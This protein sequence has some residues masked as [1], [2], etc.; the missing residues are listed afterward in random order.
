MKNI[1]LITNQFGVQSDLERIGSEHA[2]GFDVYDSVENA[3]TAIKESLPEIVLFDVTH[4][5]TDPEIAIRRMK[6]SAP[7]SSFILIM[8]RGL[9][10]ELSVVHK[11]GA[12]DYLLY[13]FKEDR[14][15]VTID[16]IYEHI[17]LKK[18][19]Q[20]LENGKK[21]AQL[22]NWLIGE[23]DAINAVRDR[24]KSIRNSRENVFITGESGTGKKYCAE[25]IHNHCERTNR[26]FIHIDARDG[27][28]QDMER[29]LVKADGG[30]LYVSHI[31]DLPPTD[32]TVLN[33]FLASDKSNE[34]L[35]IVSSQLSDHE[36]AAH[37]NLSPDLYYRLHIVPIRMPALRERRED[38]AM[39]AEHFLDELGQKHDK[40]F[41]R[42]KKD[43]M[44]MFKIYDW[45]GNVR[46][47]KNTIRSII[48]LNPTSK[49]DI[50]LS[51]L[52]TP[53]KNIPANA[54]D[55]N[56]GGMG[57]FETDEIVSIPDLER[58]AIKHALEVCHGNVQEAAMR[59]KI[60][61]ATLYRKRE[62]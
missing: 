60:S 36:L 3:E 1:F 34:V 41:R 5:S 29:A 43:I 14:V 37:N 16:N 30:T 32:Q 33:S 55:G 35:V 62:I 51:M 46:E 15:L 23:S 11:M 26:A 53:L 10:Q 54:N 48:L 20:S 57:I 27:S 7:D 4:Q 39:I 24:I 12:R 40:N 38:I 61:P 31:E 45:P 49:R 28:G 2:L 13:P 9:E 22:E 42:F 47:L 44:D 58:M 17:R 6:K 52:P 50:D 59:L 19:L 56:K 21:N 8:T 25:S 18:K